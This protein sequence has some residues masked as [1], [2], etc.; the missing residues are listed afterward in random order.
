MPRQRY[1]KKQRPSIL[2]SDGE[3]HVETF[4][5]LRHLMADD[6]AF[7]KYAA[8]EP[9][10]LKKIFRQW[11]LENEAII[12]DFNQM[13]DDYESLRGTANERASRIEELE[14]SSSTEALPAQPR[15]VSSAERADF[16]SRIEQAAEE[17]QEL[18]STNSAVRAENANLRDENVDLRA[19]I[20]IMDRQ[21][22]ETPGPS[23][24]S[25]SK[26]IPDPS[27]F[28]GG[29]TAQYRSWRTDMKFKMKV[30][31]DHY[32]SE[33][34]KI[35]YVVTRLTE[36]ARAY[37][38]PFINP[39]SPSQLIT[40][41]E[42]F[43]RLDDRY[44][45]PNHQRAA[46][47][48]YTRLRQGGLDFHDFLGRFNSLAA[49]AV[50][51]ENDQMWDLKD[52]LSTGMQKTIQGY[53]PSSLNSFIQHLHAV[54]YDYKNIARNEEQRKRNRERAAASSSGTPP[55]S[56]GTTNP[57]RTATTPA[58]PGA[59]PFRNKEGQQCFRC[60][61][62]DHLARFCPQSQPKE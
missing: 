50:I 62:K 60:G 32:Q 36:E 15:P 21:R 55:P 56:R 14:S 1:E 33:D 24:S 59:Q 54:N 51:S 38:E 44:D 57:P 22:S 43:Q 4:Q 20:R 30:N 27:Q 16:E 31:A 8:E 29:H 42:V 48:E 10:D 19:E 58:N 37:M 11:I 45:D 12:N 46:R 41:G 26:K 18:E 25:S 61:S 17:Q 53:V 9:A 7:K 35:A 23:G 34:S 2:A 5:H 28:G 6:A 52:K 47:A 39:D 49:D 3:F 40:A 13:V